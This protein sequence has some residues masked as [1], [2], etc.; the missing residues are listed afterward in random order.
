MKLTIAVLPGDGIGPEVMN[1]AIKV[2][3]AIQTVFLHEITYKY[4]AIGAD[5]IVQTGSP[6]PRMTVDTCLKADAVLLG[7]VGDPAHDHATVRPEQGLLSL[8]KK[9]KLFA[10]I[11]PVKA[12]DELQHLSAL[13]VDR[14][15]NV[16]VLIYRELSSGIYF[17]QQTRDEHSAADVCYYNKAEIERISHLAFQAAR[18]R[19]KRLTLVDK[20]N[21][22]ETSR[23]WR[24][25]VKDI[26]NEYLDVELNFMYVDNAAMQVIQAPSQFDVLLTSNMF[27]DIISDAA[28]VLT[29]TLGMLPSASIGETCPLYEPVHGSYPT[30]A[31]KDIANP[32]AMILSAAMLLEHFGLI[33][34]SKTIYEAVNQVIGQQLGTEDMSPQV[35][36]S[37]SELGNLIAAL[38]LDHKTEIN[39]FNKENIAQSLGTII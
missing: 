37:C 23:L 7:A 33:A 25:V 28:S 15:K 8:R 39:P 35:L 24:E 32:I 1:Q 9:L 10:N 29:G 5:A 18:L 17:G 30:A 22:L 3:D 13:K 26:H 16:D 20:A 27:G 12:Y 34:E 38:I 6:L 11:R 21:V 36:L 19:N 31:K 2:L 14:I 4:A